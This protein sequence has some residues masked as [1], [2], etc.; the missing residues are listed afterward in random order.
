MAKAKPPATVDEFLKKLEHPLKPEI[1]AVR[2]IIL[3]ADKRIGEGIKWNAPSF[4]TGEY[5]ATFNLR[6]TDSVELILHFGA[7]VRDIPARG[8]TIDDPAGLLK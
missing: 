1:E 6:S 3:A 4:H 5:F 8:L 2:R 7:K